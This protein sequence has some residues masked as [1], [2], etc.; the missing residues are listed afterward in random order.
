MI[1]IEDFFY[2]LLANN[3]PDQSQEI[4]KTPLRFIREFSADL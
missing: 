4:K 1:Y 2:Q 3:L